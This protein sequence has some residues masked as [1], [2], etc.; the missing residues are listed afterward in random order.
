MERLNDPVNDREYRAKQRN[1]SAKRM[2]KTITKNLYTYLCVA[3]P[4][5]FLSTIWTDFTFPPLGWGLMG[6]GILTVVLMVVG[7]R[8]MIKVGTFGGKLDDEYIDAKKRYGLAVKAAKERSIQL[9]T[10]FCEWQ[11]DV[12]F[13]RAKRARCSRLRIKYEDY[14]EKYEGKSLE[15]LKKLLPLEKAV[16]VDL[17]NKMEPIELTPDMLL[18]GY[19]RREERHRVTVSGEEY[20]ESRIYG[21]KGL[22]I[23]VVTCVVCIGLPLTFAGWPTLSKVI[24]TLGKLA[25]L[26]FRMFKGYSDGAKAYHTIEVRHLNSKSEYLEE[27]AD[28]YD[29]KIYL[30]IA[31]E[32]TQI[33]RIL[34]LRDNPGNGDEYVKI[35]CI[36][37]H[38]EGA[39]DG[40]RDGEP[41]PSAIEDHHGAEPRGEERCGHHDGALHIA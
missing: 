35:S 15:E 33:N 30:T 34:G 16:A 27:Y 9:L 39:G 38:Q 3:I 1:E 24:Y 29:K 41:D 25:V 23:S 19:S 37:P 20:E 8:L 28:F 32:Y 36:E 21:K 5:F 14:R 10:P 2:A 22:V 6:D 13:E 26:L 7:E 18:Y 31:N 11:I 12:E 4:L 17:I 40:H